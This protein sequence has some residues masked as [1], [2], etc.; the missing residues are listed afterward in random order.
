MSSDE[1]D[2]GGLWAA[3]AQAK[4]EYVLIGAFAAVLHGSPLPTMDIDICPRNDDENM[5]RLAGMLL[6]TGR[7]LWSRT[8]TPIAKTH[9]EATATLRDAGISSLRTRF[10]RLDIIIEPAGTAGFADLARDA[11]VFDI[12]GVPVRV[13]SLR[14]VIRSKQA[15]GRE[16]DLAQLP[17][18]RKLLERGGE[19]AT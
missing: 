3:L 5:S 16:T 10:G 18:L 17:I 7:G 1:L 14:D 8:G 12:E 2:P 9:G 6:T 11:R 19:T 4:V 13:A 15:S